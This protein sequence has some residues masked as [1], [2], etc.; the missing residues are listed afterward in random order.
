MSTSEMNTIEIS[1]DKLFCSETNGNLFWFKDSGKWTYHR[2]GDKPA[3]EYV[4]GSKKYYQHGVLNRVRGPASIGPR[5]GM[6]F[7]LNGE[8]LTHLKW[9][10]LTDHKV[11]DRC[12]RFCRQACKRKVKIS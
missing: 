9:A 11:C 10:N 2:D 6:A 12:L 7:Y 4:D 3:I 5:G 1:D 8:P